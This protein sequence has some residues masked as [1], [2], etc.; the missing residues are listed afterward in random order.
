MGWRQLI[1]GLFC[2]ALGLELML[3]PLYLLGFSHWIWEPFYWCGGILLILGG[4]AVDLT[5]LASFWRYFWRLWNH[6]ATS[7]SRL[8]AK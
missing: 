8:L 1:F 7:R 2:M 3:A 4:F 5:A 6:L